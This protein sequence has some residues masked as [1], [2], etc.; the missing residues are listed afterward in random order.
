MTGVPGQ[1]IIRATGLPAKLPAAAAGRDFWPAVRALVGQLTCDAPEPDPGPGAEAGAPYLW[2]LL[3]RPG[4]EEAG[5]VAGLWLAG[6]LAGQGR[7]TLLLDADE[8]EQVLT[9]RGGRLFKAGWLDMARYG[10]SL[11]A[12]AAQVEW[13]GREGLFLGLGSYCP[14]EITPQEVQGLLRQLAGKVDDVV[15]VCGM[16]QAAQPWYAAEADPWYCWDQATDGKDIPAAVLADLEAR[17]QSCRGV[18]ACGEEP[19]PVTVPRQEAIA[20]PAADEVPAAVTSADAGDPGSS[21]PGKGLPPASVADAHSSGIFRVVALTGLVTVALLAVFIWKFTDFGRPEPG[22]LGP[23][24]TAGRGSL[25]VAPDSAGQVAALVDSLL[26]TGPDASASGS[27]DSPDVAMAAPGAAAAVDSAPGSGAGPVGSDSAQGSAGGTPVK[28][29]TTPGDPAAV[30]ADVEPAFSRTVGSDGWC[31]HVYSLRDS[32]AALR[33][34]RMIEA[35]GIWAVGAPVVLRD[36]G[37]W[38]RVYVGS[39]PSRRAALD[40]EPALKWKLRTDW[41]RPAKLPDS[42]WD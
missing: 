1:P 42:A 5:A 13:E 32:T 41:A 11:A 15:V 9:T 36:S 12:A 35:K 4:G 18:L 2:L 6:C 7:R 3:H 19:E 23:V 25:P 22:P 21:G 17:G 29:P 37:R 30:W 8:A 27:Q 26:A 24:T 20:A 16:G 33:E 31:L 40:A 39:F 38:Y 34:I 10:T 14:P 28:E